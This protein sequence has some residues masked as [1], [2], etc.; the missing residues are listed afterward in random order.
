[1]NALSVIAI[2]LGRGNDD[3]RPCQDYFI[4]TPRSVLGWCPE[5]NALR[6]YFLK[7]DSEW[8]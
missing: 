3:L 1:M 4:Y 6:D 5:K 2:Y 8:N 7:Q